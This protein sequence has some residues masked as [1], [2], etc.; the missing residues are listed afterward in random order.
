[1]LKTLYVYKNMDQISLSNNFVLKSFYANIYMSQFNVKNLI[2]TWVLANKHHKPKPN[3]KL[4]LL[5]FSSTDRK[6]LFLKIRGCDY[7]V[8]KSVHYFYIGLH[9]SSD[10]L[11]LIAPI[12]KHGSNKSYQQINAKNIIFIQKHGSINKSYQQFYAKNL[13]CIQKHGSNKS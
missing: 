13:I 10:L 4:L 5:K 1:M 6:H 12:Q 11:E 3:L 8:Y 2:F 9:S 7:F